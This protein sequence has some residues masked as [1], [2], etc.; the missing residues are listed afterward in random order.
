M[1]GN[2]I[3][4]TRSLLTPTYKTEILPEVTRIKTKK[5]FLSD[6]HLKT[7]KMKSNPTRYLIF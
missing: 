4:K 5:M 6:N 7:F 2:L 3:T 1:I